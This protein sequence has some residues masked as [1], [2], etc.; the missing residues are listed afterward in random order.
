M[1]IRNTDY[2]RLLA[3]CRRLHDELEDTMDAI[4]L[5]VTDIELAVEGIHISF[6]VIDSRMNRCTEELRCLAETERMRSQSFQGS[7]STSVP[8]A[9]E[10]VRRF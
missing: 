8:E 9:G 5:L 7:I 3:D 1:N 6:E 4:Q 2:T 10:G